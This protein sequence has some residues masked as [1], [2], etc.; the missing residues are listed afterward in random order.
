MRSAIIHDERDRLIPLSHLTE[1][2]TTT[3]DLPG[4]IA[5]RAGPINFGGF[6]GTW[7][8]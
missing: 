6:G 2:H 4:G 1:L 8:Q 7:N 3:G 5:L